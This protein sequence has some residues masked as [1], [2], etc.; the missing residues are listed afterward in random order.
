MCGSGMFQEAGLAGVEGTRQVGQPGGGNC[1]Q[2]SEQ[3][4]SRR[5]GKQYGCYSN[6]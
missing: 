1:S 4:G 3:A 2:E 5:H 6:R